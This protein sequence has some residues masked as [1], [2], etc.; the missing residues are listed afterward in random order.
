MSGVARTVAEAKESAEQHPPNFAIIDIRLANGDVGTE[1]GAYLR[2]T[3]PSLGIIYST[4]NGADVGLSTLEGDAVMTKPY[5]LRDVA[6][7]LEIVEQLRQLGQTRLRHPRNFRL[8]D[9]PIV[10]PVTRRRGKPLC[11]ADCVLWSPLDALDRAVSV[12]VTS[13][14]LRE[15]LR[16]KRAGRLS[17]A[18]IPFHDRFRTALLNRPCAGHKRTSRKI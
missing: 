15:G 12:T 2:A 4:G 3:T 13:P 18:A 8:L 5:R 17:T 14:D 10:T 6:R 1:F 16:I 11:I 9:P 7:G